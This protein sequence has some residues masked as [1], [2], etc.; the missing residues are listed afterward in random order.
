MFSDGS[1]Q[2][3]LSRVLTS[4]R[5]CQLPR[6]LFDPS[7]RTEPLRLQRKRSVCPGRFS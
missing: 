4:Y 6:P 5:Q 2:I 3:R 1:Y 7:T